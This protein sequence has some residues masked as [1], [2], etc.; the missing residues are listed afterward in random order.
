MRIQTKLLILLLAIALLPLALLSLRG[1]RATEN[2]GMAIADR[3]HAIVTATIENH[4]QQAIGYA[5][6]VLSAQQRQAELAL[7]LQAAEIERRLQKPAPPQARHIYRT[8]AFFDP[9][10][11][12]PGTELALDH[13]M[14]ASGQELRPVP[15]SRLHQAFYVTLLAGDETE[16]PPRIAAEM[17]QLASMDAAYK[18]VAESATG[19]FY[20]QYVALRD[21]LLSVYPG[22]GGYPTGF[23]P[24][25]RTWY[26]LAVGGDGLAW[27]PPTL[28]AATRRLLLT[29]SMP[30]YDA[31][32]HIAG[33]TGIDVDILARLAELQGRQQLGA[34]TASYVVRVGG[35][36]GE[37]LEA[38]EKADSYTL[39]VIAA[40]SYADTGTAWDAELDEPLFLSDDTA[41]LEAVI[42]DLRSGRNGL[43]RMSR[44]SAAT[45]WIYG[46]VKSLNAALLY[47]VPSASVAAIADEAWDSIW[48][49]TTEQVRLAGLASLALMIVVALI[50]AVSAPFRNG[51]FA[52]AGAGCEGSGGGP[53]RSASDHRKP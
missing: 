41:G 46:P 39:R 2:L 45:V 14:A 31:N 50:A 8:R 37:R 53:S 34:D 19:L 10:T 13:A 29:V 35:P 21:G 47:V 4:L 6:D 17:R 5:S 32:G 18:R 26:R 42:E 44:G 15:I 43:R 27:S 12:P 25:L 1:Q 40:S 30:V 3:G 48:R 11:W 20:W 9:D 33:V 28:D 23:D 38:D 49:A 36:N 16:V 7:R 52:A 51:T 24:R 22:H